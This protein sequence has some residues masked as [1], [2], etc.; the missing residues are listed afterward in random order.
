MARKKIIPTVQV[1]GKTN[2]DETLL[3][4]IIRI[5]HSSKTGLGIAELG[6]SIADVSRKTIS[7][8][9]AWLRNDGWVATEGQTRNTTYR[10]A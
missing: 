1:S 3:N 4:R 2:L 10:L 8:H 5:L 9:I 6:A 7:K